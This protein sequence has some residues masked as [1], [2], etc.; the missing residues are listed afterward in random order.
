MIS[1]LGIAVGACVAVAVAGATW[2]VP[3]GRETL[4]TPF[5]E[6][7]IEARWAV[8]DSRATAVRDLAMRQARVWLPPDPST[9]DPA[10]NPGDPDGNLSGD[11]VRCRYLAG[12]AK[13]T[14][15]KFDCI[16]SSFEIV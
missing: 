10:A 15:P 5:A 9:A 7:R 12:P 3:R 6:P 2:L 11:L 4:Q 13:G 8:D 14:T 16:L 1:R